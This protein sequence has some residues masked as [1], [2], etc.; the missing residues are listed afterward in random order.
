MAW[1]LGIETSCDET[2]V[3]IAD[4]TGRVLAEEVASQTAL[5]APHGGI[6]PEI[7]A[8]AHLELLPPLVARV[9]A[10]C[11]QPP[12]AIDAVAAT[13]GPGLKVALV[14]GVSFAKA[15]AFGWDRPFVA[16]HHLEAHALSPGMVEDTA[17][18]Y[19]LLLVSGG[20]TQLLVVEDVGRYHL[21]GTTI[22]DAA[23]ETFDKGARLLGLGYPGGPAIARA[24]QGGDPHRFDLPRPLAGSTDF[25]FSFAGLKTALAEQVRRLGGPAALDPATRRDLAASLEQ[26]IVDVLI[27]RIERALDHYRATWRPARPVLVAAGG[28][29]ANARL[30]AALAELAAEK[31]VEVVIPPQRYCTDNA[32]MVAHAGALRFTR[33]WSDGLDAPVRARWPL[34]EARAGRLGG[35]AKGPKA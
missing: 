27:D 3:A 18:P 30:R 28:V 10:R 29:A 4:E 22:D 20:H 13:T 1:V 24:A 16:V 11:G 31:A 2:A 7:A 23:G 17:F 35:G 26:A 15:L 9:L 5:H 32:A 25:V 6:V 12:S 34:D 14:V 19:L 33:G 21:L 8:R